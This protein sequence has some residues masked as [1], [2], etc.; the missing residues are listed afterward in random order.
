MEESLQQFIIIIT[1]IFI[2]YQIYLFAYFGGKKFLSIK[3]R[4][5]KFTSDCN[6]LNEHIEELKSS[7]LGISSTDYG[8]AHLSDD[9]SYKMKRRKWSEETINHRTHNCSST[10]VKNASNQPFKYL[11]KY[12]NIDQTEESLSEFEDVLN[13]FSAAEQGKIL[14]RAERDSI[15]SSVSGQI[16]SVIRMFSKPRLIR[17]LGFNDIDFSQ[18]YIPVYTF[19]YVS[20]G[21]NS[22]SKSE[23]R[24]DVQNLNGFVSYLGGLVKFR[25]SVKGQRLLMTSDLRE[26]IKVRDN[27]TCKMCGASVTEEKNLLLEIDHILPI[28][29]GGMTTEEN[30]QALCWR[31]NRTKGSK[32]ISNTPDESAASG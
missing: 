11:C 1:S 29:K 13:D 8:A 23:I 25:K 5:E 28:S 2:S 26:R 30:L 6:A 18:L 21:G 32:V 27:F 20:A 9:S 3:K 15:V 4:V 22:S 14:L 24:L 10:V 16:P 12:F 31:C 17:E 19:Q 7:Y